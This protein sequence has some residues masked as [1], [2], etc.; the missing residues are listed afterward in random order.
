MPVS[1][2][3]PRSGFTLPEMLIV[4]TVFGI[5]VG[6]I[7]T[8]LMRQQQFY[9]G[10]NEVLTMRAQLRQGL[11]AIVADLRAISPVGGDVYALTTRAIEFRSS[12]GA[13]IA[14]RVT[15]T[16]TIV[17]PPTVLSNGNA[18]TSWQSA[19]VATD[20]FFVY[21]DS[22]SSLLAGW[23][24]YKI[25]SIT[26]VTD[27]GGCTAATGF[28]QA[29]DQAQKSYRIQI[30]ATATLPTTVQIG[31]PIR[32]FRRARY[33]LYQATDTKWYLGYYDCVA[34]RMPVCNPLRP[35][36]GPFRNFSANAE[37]SGLL[38]SYFDQNGAALAAAIWNAP[39][40]ARITISLRGQ[41]AAPVSMGGGAPALVA[42]SLVMDVA[43][44]N[45][46]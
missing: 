9:R 42:D 2:R 38:F 36:A 7:L 17:I 1:I 44:R 11:G 31:A 27:T 18:L 6:G 39:Y 33:E 15:N 5:T 40:V 45:R 10:A 29:A 8:V 30:P 23:K 20:S 21:D 3:R 16:R 32:F 28:V 25:E 34:G 46:Q 37:Q 14:C 43:I 26:A 35:M 19:P 12:I 24:A 22:T 41:T 4:M 13:S